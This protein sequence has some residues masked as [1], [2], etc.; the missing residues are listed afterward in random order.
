MDDFSR[1]VW[2]FL[3]K[4]KD[5]VYDN[6]VMFSNMLKN[7]F[8]KSIKVI[9]SDNGTEFVNSRV[10]MFC[11]N[12]GILHQT[13]CVHTPQQ[14]GVVERKH[15]HLMNVARALLFQSHLPLNLWGETVMTATFLINR[16]PSSVLNGKSSFEVI[17]GKPPRLHFLRTFGCL[18]F[19]TRL[20]NSDKFSSRS[21]KCVFIGYSNK[22]KGYKVLSLDNN[23]VFFSRDVK[24]YETIFPFQMSSSIFGEKQGC[25]GVLN[26]DESI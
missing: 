18:C 6:I 2:I 24:F 8:S 7:Q 3:L 17:Y 12:Q 26:S 1:A 4:G 9:R 5:E 25:N 23:T 11:E 20:N 10:N 19:T 15:R 13:T 14:N 22:K 16:V 21:D